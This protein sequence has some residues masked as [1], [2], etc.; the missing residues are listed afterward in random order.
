MLPS[1]VVWMVMESAARNGN[2]AYAVS[3]E[4]APLDAETGFQ[5]DVF[6]GKC[7]MG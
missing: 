6:E 3:F 1:C 4:F 2:R 7:F 5:F